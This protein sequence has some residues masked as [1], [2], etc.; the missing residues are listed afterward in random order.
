VTPRGC[1][2]HL[3]ALTEIEAGFDV[4]GAVAERARM[5]LEGCEVCRHR[6]EE[7][8][9]AIV[10]LRRLRAEVEAA[11]PSAEAWDR[12]QRRVIAEAAERVAPTPRR[13][14][15]AFPVLSALTGAFL[16][17]T[18]AI[19]AALGPAGAPQALV[20]PGTQADVSTSGIDGRLPVEL[21]RPQGDGSVPLP[22]ELFA[23]DP[24]DAIQPAARSLLAEVCPTSDAQGD[25]NTG[26]GPL[27]GGS[28]PT[29]GRL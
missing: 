27:P 9:L 21:V 24:V 1:A 22:F 23:P 5:H 19:P 25:C 28:H 26:G 16:L 7:T 14:P 15:I 2:R 18:L 8:A 10:G 4:P 13:L 3:D 11:E 12:L 20:E 17:I 6:L 29:E